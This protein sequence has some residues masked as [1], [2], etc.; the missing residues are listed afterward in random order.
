MINSRQRDVALIGA[1]YWGKN[2]LRNFDSLEVLHTVC[3]LSPNSLDVFKKDYSHLNYTSDFESI[4]SNP[5]I[6]K[7]VIAT[8]AQ[9]HYSVAK[10]A[11]EAGKDVFIE[12]PLCLNP[13]EGEE[14]IDLARKNKVIIF[15]GHLFHYHPYVKELKRVIEKGTIGDLQYISSH[16]LNLGKIRQE[17]NSLWSLAPHDISL[18]LSLCKYDTVQSMSCFGGTEQTPGICDTSMLH[19]LFESGVR[20]HIYVSWL[21]PVKERRLIVTGTK[22]MLVFDD[23]LPWEEKLKLFQNPVLRGPKE[24]ISHNPHCKGN[25]IVVPQKEPLLEECRAFLNYC[26]KR[27]QPLTD[28]SEGLRVLETLQF[29]EE[30]MNVSSG[31][32]AA[33][34]V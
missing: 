3:D 13:P 7:I 20:S 5:D 27:E 24:S 17:E 18:I 25:A 29:A 6:N 10:M 15:V 31:Y 30:S 1:G 28:G 23:M 11:I 32:E 19:I 34:S 33:L 26:E 8:P 21:S 9:T 14:L 4:L 16:R 22:G 2:L 12:K